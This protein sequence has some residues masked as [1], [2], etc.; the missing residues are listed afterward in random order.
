MGDAGHEYLQL[1]KRIESAEERLLTLELQVSIMEAREA[2]KVSLSPEGPL[3]SGAVRVSETDDRPVGVD[4]HGRPFE[5]GFA[6][7]SWS[8]EPDDDDWM[9]RLAGLELPPEGDDQ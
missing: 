1:L 7:D 4:E 3:P 8:E 5:R 2:D 6:K 9:E